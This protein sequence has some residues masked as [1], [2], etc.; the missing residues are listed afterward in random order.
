MIHSKARQ[1]IV[2]LLLLASPLWAK[3]EKARQSNTADHIEDHRQSDL[4]WDWV[5]TEAVL[6]SG[7][8][9]ECER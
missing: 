2:L 6:F 7:N 5:I 4:P 8:E 3:Q 1:M 9:N